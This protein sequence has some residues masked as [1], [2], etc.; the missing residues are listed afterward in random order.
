MSFV[1]WGGLAVGVAALLGVGGAGVATAGT[2]NPNTLLG[3]TVS[4]SGRITDAATGQGVAGM[5][6]EATWQE[7]SY[8]ATSRSDGNYTVTWKQSS[9]PTP[10]DV[11]VAA[12]AYCGANGW[13]LA[14]PDYPKHATVTA[15]T[16]HSAVSGV[17]LQTTRA[18]RIIGKVTDDTTGKPVSGVTVEW[19]TQGAA[20]PTTSVL[21]VTTQ[22]DGSYVVGGLPT[23][24]YQLVIN[25]TEHPGVAQVPTRGLMDY[26]TDYVHHV[27]D[28]GSARA[29]CPSRFPQPPA[30]A[31]SSTSPSTQLTRSPGT[32]T[33]SGTGV[34]LPNVTVLAWGGSDWNEGGAY[35]TG[36]TDALGRYRVDGLG[37]GTYKLCFEPDVTTPVLSSYKSACWKNQPDEPWNQTGNTI[38]V[39]GFGTVVTGIDQGLTSSS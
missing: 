5:C 22:S 27:S 3:V 6:V 7:T 20:Y 29:P 14:T 25:P 8:T 26:L 28:G 36:Y 15:T 19:R 12:T 34:P 1:R 31:L 32:V 33:D 24:T 11:Y 23:G 35:T 37:P 21:E 10:E 30:R 13:W 39:D 38:V 18:A 4:V 2:P 9:N 16:G 17:D